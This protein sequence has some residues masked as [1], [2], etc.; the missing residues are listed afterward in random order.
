MFRSVPCHSGCTG[1]T[2]G[3]RYLVPKILSGTLRGRL[4]YL[5]LKLGAP[6]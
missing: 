5:G 1:R 4:M 3:V 6:G 2:R